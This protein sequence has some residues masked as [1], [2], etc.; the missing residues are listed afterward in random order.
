MPIKHKFLSHKWENDLITEN[1][2]LKPKLYNPEIL[3]LGTFNPNTPNDNHADFFYGRNWFWPAFKNLFIKND[4]IEL[5]RRMP[6]N[7]KPVYP[8]NPELN[9]VFEICKRGKITFADLITCVFPDTDQYIILKNDNVV[10]NNEEFN[11][12]NDNIRDGVKGLAELDQLKQIEWN[13]E[14]IVSYLEKNK[15][16]KNVYLTRNP[17]GIWLKKWKQLKTNKKL[18][19]INFKV[20]YTPS[21]ANLRGTPRIKSLIQHWLFNISKNYNTLDHQWL[22]ENGVN[23]EKFK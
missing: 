14:N 11:L 4:L 19:N 13:V 20:I 10:F 2:I 5:N 6:S 8:L 21:A 7:G 16:I 3:I 23:I 22:Y 12:I 18:E 1:A 15:T 17:T 9:E